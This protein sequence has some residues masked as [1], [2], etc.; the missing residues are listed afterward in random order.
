MYYLTSS[1]SILEELGFTP[2]KIFGSLYGVRITPAQYA[3]FVIKYSPIYF[4]GPRSK[5]TKYALWLTAPS[6][7][8]YYE[9]EE[10]LILLKQILGE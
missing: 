7:F 4:S 1:Q 10:I 6:K 8:I 9:S 3:Y 2:K 5:Y